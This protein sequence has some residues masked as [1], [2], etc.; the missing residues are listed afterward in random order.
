MSPRTIQISSTLAAI[1]A[2]IAARKAVAAVWGKQRD[3]APAMAAAVDPKAEGGSRGALLFL[4]AS[5]VA[6]GLAR[7]LAR[8]ATTAVGE[9]QLA[10][11][12]RR[13]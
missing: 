1:G 12:D 8:A 5:A 13:H 3:T 11:A 2:G 4:V 9:R 7:S 6:G 10:T